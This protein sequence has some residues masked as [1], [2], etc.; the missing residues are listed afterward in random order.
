MNK[1]KEK[2]IVLHNNTFAR[3]VFLWRNKAVIMKGKRIFEVAKKELT[4]LNPDVIA[5]TFD[6]LRNDFR[7]VA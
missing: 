6:F 2:D 7:Y 1:I 4:P 3:V 5:E